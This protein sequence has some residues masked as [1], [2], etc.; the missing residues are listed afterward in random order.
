MWGW[1]TTISVV[2]S[3]SWCCFYSMAPVYLLFKGKFLDNGEACNLEYAVR[4]HIKLQA[5]SSCC[6]VLFFHQRFKL[7]YASTEK[8]D[9]LSLQ[10]PE[11]NVLPWPVWKRDFDVAAVMLKLEIDFLVNTSYRGDVKI[12][13]FGEFLI[14]T[15]NK[16]QYFSPSCFDQE[17]QKDLS[18]F[19][20]SCHSR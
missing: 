1:D 19:E 16:I 3:I 7:C 15:V 18:V 6:Q 2:K 14:V 5:V 9:C 4:H 12:W 10:Q 20:S 17:L 8:I 11:Q 13:V